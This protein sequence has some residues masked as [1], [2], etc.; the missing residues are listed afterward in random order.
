MGRLS[1]RR[2]RRVCRGGNGRAESGERRAGAPL[3]AFLTPSLA[4]GRKKRL[5]QEVTER[6]EES[7]AG[8]SVLSVT[9]CS[10]CLVRPL[11]EGG[12]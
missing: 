10:K 11:G 2:E 7:S 5:K 3:A 12:S 8:L 6:T 9:F 4:V 1:S